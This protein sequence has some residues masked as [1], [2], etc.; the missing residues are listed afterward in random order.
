ML[1]SKNLPRYPY[2]F[3]E[4][5]Y[6]AQKGPVKKPVIVLFSSVLVRVQESTL[7]LCWDYLTSPFPFLAPPASIP[8]TPL[9]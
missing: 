6:H 5:V 3:F 8:P 9:K 7:C 4:V 2:L 1:F